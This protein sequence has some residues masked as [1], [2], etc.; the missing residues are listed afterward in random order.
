MVMGINMNMK[1]KSWNSTVVFI[2]YCLIHT[3]FFNISK[4]KFT[5]TVALLDMQACRDASIQ[6]SVQI[7]N[8]LLYGQNISFLAFLN[9]NDWHFWLGVGTM[10]CN[11]FKGVLHPRPILWLHFSQKNFNT[12]WQVRYVSYVTF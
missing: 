8:Q 12:W 9:H 11:S 6:A 5:P 10:F 1:L 3:D 7:F 2:Y 4:T